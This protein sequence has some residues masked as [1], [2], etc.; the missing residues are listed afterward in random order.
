MLIESIETLRQIGEF[1]NRLGR[2]QWQT[3]FVENVLSPPNGNVVGVE[4]QGSYGPIIGDR[5]SGSL[6][7]VEKIHRIGM[8]ANVGKQILEAIHN[9]REPE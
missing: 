6:V 1:F 7:N 3:V 9:G 2:G 5:R 4:W 8:F